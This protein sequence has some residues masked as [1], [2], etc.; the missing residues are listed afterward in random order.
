MSA[1]RKAAVDV[2]IPPPRDTFVGPLLRYTMTY[3]ARPSHGSRITLAVSEDI[4]PLLLA[5]SVS[6]MSNWPMTRSNRIPVALRDRICLCICMEDF[7]KTVASALARLDRSDVLLLVPVCDHGILNSVV[8]RSAHNPIIH[9]IPLAAIGSEANNAHSPTP[10]HPWHL[11]QLFDAG[12]IYVDARLW[13]EDR[14][15]SLGSAARVS[16]L[17]LRYPSQTNAQHRNRQNRQSPYRSHRFILPPL[18]VLRKRKIDSAGEYPVR[19][20]Q[21]QSHRHHAHRHHHQASMPADCHGL[22]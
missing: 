11:Q 18:A 20:L 15:R 14:C 22:N 3:S 8:D 7:V 21:M 19:F 5:G 10:R 6:L 4:L 12:T 9:Q 13:R 17:R 16:I 1:A 2:R